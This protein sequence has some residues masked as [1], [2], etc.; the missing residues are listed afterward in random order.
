MAR[1]AP[2]RVRA[3]L[4]RRP[5]PH[6]RGTRR[7][8]PGLSGPAQRLVAAREAALGEPP[9]ALAAAVAAWRAEAHRRGRPALG[10]PCPCCEADHGRPLIERML[11][12]LPRHAARELRAVVAPL[13]EAYRASRVRRGDEFWF[14]DGP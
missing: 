12:A 8:V 7:V 10:P 9:G 3:G 6:D 11:H 14:L 13:D 5:R 4:G 1:N 2:A